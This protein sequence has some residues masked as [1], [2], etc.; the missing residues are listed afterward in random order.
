[1]WSFHQPRRF[2]FGLRYGLAVVLTMVCCMAVWAQQTQIRQPL[3][4]IVLPAHPVS[5][6]ISH[7]FAWFVDEHGSKTVAD[8]DKADFKP[9]NGPFN[10]GYSKKT[11]WLRL[12]AQDS[13]TRT[14]EWWL[15]VEPPYL[16]RVDLYEPMADG[17]FRMRTAGDRLAFTTRAV[18]HSNFVF[19]IS[20]Q[21]QGSTYYLRIQSSGALWVK[22]HIWHDTLF[23]AASTRQAH[24]VGISTGI[25]L[26]LMFTALLQGMVLREPVYLAFVAYVAV[27]VVLLTSGVIS[28]H[29]PANWYLL[30]DAVPPVILCLS[31]AAYAIFCHFFLYENQQARVFHGLFYVLAAIGLLSA[32]LT[33][34]P[35]FRAFI[36]LVVICKLGGTVLPILAISSRLIRGSAYTR[37]VWLGVVS[38]IVAQT[39][40]MA[41]LTGTIDENSNWATL[42]VFNAIMVLHLLLLSFALFERMRRVNRERHQSQR[43]LA[44][45]RLLKEASDK[46]AQDQRSFLAMVAHELRGPLAVARSA[47][48]NLRQLVSGSDNELINTRLDRTDGS[49]QQMAALIETCL[50]HERQGQAQP[51]SLQQ[52]VCLVELQ[53]QTMALLTEAAR[54]RVLWP[55]STGELAAQGNV[56]LLAIAL[57]NLIENACRYDLSGQA[58]EVNWQVHEHCLRINVQDR[59][60][61]IPQAKMTQLFEPF[62]RSG[63]TNE[64][65][66]PEPEGLGLGLYIV[67]R[68][69]SMHGGSAY[70]QPREGGGTAFVLEL[71]QLP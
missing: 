58:V 66:S 51:L 8:M 11:F 26:L 6:D 27:T 59:G 7:Q 48:F 35:A 57:R 56:A 33:V 64:A 54:Q 43:E 52:E 29:T 46:M 38:N 49:L 16:D 62:V 37:V 31:V 39:I 36:P 69:A 15:E 23:A 9:L 68:I 34:M 3:G 32:A 60:L 53:E 12:I 41:R 45:Q 1:M 65:T 17:S 70:A 67:G 10:V 25:L 4:T 22:A 55:K 71:T 5:I 63:A 13:L 30:N 24:W 2:S 42:H 20:P 61:G 47:S 44:T 14:R 19:P 18:P 50:S 28:L 40:L 21:A